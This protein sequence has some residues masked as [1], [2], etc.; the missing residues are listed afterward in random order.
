LMEGGLY[1]GGTGGKEWKGKIRKKYC[2][3]EPFE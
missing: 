3:K 2:N 1:G